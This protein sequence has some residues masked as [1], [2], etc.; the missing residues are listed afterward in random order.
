MKHL[1]SSRLIAW[2]LLLAL[3]LWFGSCKKDDNP[4]VVDTPTVEGSYKITALKANPKV[5]G[6]YD[7]LLAA[8]PLILKTS[9]LNDITL[10]FQT[11]G[12]IKTDNP[13]SCQNS[14]IPPGTITGIDASSKWALNGKTLTITK[15]NGTQ[16]LYTILSSGAVL[17][18]QWQ[19]SQDYLGTGTKVAYT[20]TMDLTK[21]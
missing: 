7:D 17:Q 1:H 2:T 3:P 18:V 9:C 11:G 14:T 10:T 8:A 21:Q 16:T 15:S 19:D 20:Y 4:T 6:I 12:S 5:G 13:T